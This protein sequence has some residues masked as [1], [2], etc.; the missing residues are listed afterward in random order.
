VI[1]Q[2]YNIKLSRLT[3]EDI[4]L[5][6]E[7]RNSADIRKYMIYQKYIEPDAQLKWFHNINNVYNI[8]LLIEVDGKK[9]GLVNGKNSDFKK[10]ESEGGIFV[11]D[12]NYRNTIIPALVSVI[13]LDYIF[14][15]CEFEKSYIKVLDTNKN[16]IMFNKQIG[17][18]L[19]E[20]K[21]ELG[22]SI[23]VLNKE[24]YLSKIK[25]FRKVIAK[26][27]GDGTELGIQNFSFSGVSDQD[28]QLLYGDLPGYLKQKINVVLKNE[29]RKLLE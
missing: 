6:R 25:L 2:K 16:A 12:E 15:I 19:Y 1:I 4:E 24:R 27:T 21:P 11:W 26:L 9:I 22:Y 7:K 14:L 10:K 3:L 18:E 28:I 29:N 17:Y 5:V 23:Y 20:S 13:T 8:Y